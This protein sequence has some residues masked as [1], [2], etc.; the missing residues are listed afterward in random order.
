[1]TDVQLVGDQPTRRRG[2]TQ[3]DNRWHIMV[4]LV[5]GDRLDAGTMTDKERADFRI[6]LD[7]R[8]SPSRETGPD[9]LVPRTIEI[10]SAQVYV[11]VRQILYVRWEEA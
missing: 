11:P 6:M 9:E 5:N 2:R 10:A 7:A 4:H 8:L 3:P 1:V